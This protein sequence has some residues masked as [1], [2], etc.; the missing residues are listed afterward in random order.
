MAIKTTELMRFVLVSEIYNKNENILV[1]KLTH[2][3]IFITNILK[4][5]FYFYLLNLLPLV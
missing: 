4:L 5:I 2:K 3:I 1:I